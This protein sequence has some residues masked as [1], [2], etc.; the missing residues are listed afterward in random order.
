MLP[1]LDA[2]KETDSES[3]INFNHSQRV[4]TPWHGIEWSEDKSRL[5]NENRCY[6]SQ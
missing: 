6:E 1:E 5:I 3:D 4:V 2:P